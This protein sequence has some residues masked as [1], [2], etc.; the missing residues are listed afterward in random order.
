MLE[1]KKEIYIVSKKEDYKAMKCLTGLDEQREKDF[2]DM[3]EIEISFDELNRMK[4]FNWC[5]IGEIK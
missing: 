3:K 5:V 2:N 1:E 4:Y